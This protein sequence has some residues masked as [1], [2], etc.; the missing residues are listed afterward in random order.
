MLLP[1]SEKAD[2]L[3]AQKGLT[4]SGV[5]LTHTGKKVRNLYLT[6]TLRLIF[7]GWVYMGK[8]LV[9]VAMSTVRSLLTPEKHAWLRV[10]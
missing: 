4:T 5:R 8:F 2:I 10:E 9:S 1:F 6:E 3:S 7:A